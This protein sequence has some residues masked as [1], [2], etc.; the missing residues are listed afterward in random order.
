[1]LFLPFYDRVLNS[2]DD[3]CISV[4]VYIMAVLL[5]FCS[6]VKHILDLLLDIQRD[7]PVGSVKSCFKSGAFLLLKEL[8][9]VNI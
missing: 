7:F 5:F 1:M 8:L 9:Y 3:S 6:S 4:L 2:S